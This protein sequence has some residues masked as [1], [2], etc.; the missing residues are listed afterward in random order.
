ML[1]NLKYLLAVLLNPLQ[2]VSKVITT[3]LGCP[4]NKKISPSTITKTN[5]QKN[6]NEKKSSGNRK[7]NSSQVTFSILISSKKQRFPIWCSDTPW[8]LRPCNRGPESQVWLTM[9]SLPSCVTQEE[10]LY[11]SKALSLHFPKIPLLFYYIYI[12]VLTLKGFP[13]SSV[14]KNLPVMQE[15]QETQVLSLCW[16][17]TLEEAMATHS[18]ILAWR[19]PWTEEPGRLQ[20]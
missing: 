10:S 15:P 16:E 14:A 20:G 8:N 13:T 1:I 9:L 2:H 5:K 19:I 7:K 3:D 6:L 12:V 18:S 17:D 4:M 11:P